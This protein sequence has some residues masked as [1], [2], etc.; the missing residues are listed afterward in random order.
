M[1]AILILLVTMT[2][3]GAADP[4]P[5][6]VLWVHKTQNHFVASPTTD[7]R[8]VVAPGIGAFNSAVVLGLRADPAASDRVAWMHTTPVLKMPPASSPAMSGGRVVFGTGLHQSDGGELIC[9]DA[10]SGQIQW[11]LVMEGRL[12][13]LESAPAIV[14]DR[15]WFG[16]GHGGLIC[17]DM[18][19]VTFEGDELPVEEVQR[20]L[21]TLW[22]KMKA[23]YQSDLK[24]DPDFAVPPRR[25]DLPVPSPRILW[26]AGK[27][28]W[29][30]D[31]PVRMARDCVFIT[32][33]KVAEDK[34]SEPA[35]LCVK[36]DDGSLVWRTP[37]STNPWGGVTVA[38]ELVLTGGSTIRLDPDMADKGRG[39]LVAV[40]AATGQVRWR[41]ELPG[42]VVSPVAWA[43]ALA[44]ATATDGNVRAFEIATGKE[45]WSYSATGPIFGGAVVAGETV[46]AGDLKGVLHAIAL[47]D[48]KGLWKLDVGQHP[49]IKCPGMIEATP[50]IHEGRIFVATS[51]LESVTDQHTVIICIGEK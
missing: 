21:A 48:G 3:V 19:R 47:A 12:V 46:Y 1:R 11:R 29:H 36:A 49:S 27:N 40:E 26:Q 17:A 35:V 16:A 30:V 42:G 10:V 15:V 20:R 23:Q 28:R 5:P 4:I 25:E 14:G 18:Q 43:G 24:K 2:C 34:H 13:H 50:T 41:M 38:G 39:E 44:I 51:N 8:T 32:T 9:L 7:G 22:E 33:G 31:S 37:M 6:K 45:Q